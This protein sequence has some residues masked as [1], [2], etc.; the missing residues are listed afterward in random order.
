MNLLKSAVKT[1]EITVIKQDCR[2][3]YSGLTDT[4][5]TAATAATR[6]HE[7]IVSQPMKILADPITLTQ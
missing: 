2:T 3:A 4:S 6:L 1:K 7:V 5:S